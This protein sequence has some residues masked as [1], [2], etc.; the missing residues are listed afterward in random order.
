M[1]DKKVKGTVSTVLS[2]L[3]PLALIFN[4]VA[5]PAYASAPSS[6]FSDPCP[7]SLL[8][9]GK[10]VAND[11]MAQFESV[12]ENDAS[13]AVLRAGVDGGDHVEQEAAD[14]VQTAEV[15][16]RSTADSW[17]KLAQE[18]EGT[19]E[20][21]TSRRGDVL[22]T[23]APRVDEVREDAPVLTSDGPQGGG[24]VWGTVRDAWLHFRQLR[25][26]DA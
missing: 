16:Q 5:Q 2:S 1:L 3:I 21:H 10:Q 25:I 13:S 7:N 26:R 18:D 9:V 8:V 19:T 4:A 15:S 20:S 17:E 11:V 14:Q 6:L 22:G 23:A 12:L 24:G